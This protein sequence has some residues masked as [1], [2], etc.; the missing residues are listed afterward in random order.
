MVENSDSGVRYFKLQAA[1]N[2]LTQAG[3][4]RHAPV[5]PKPHQVAAAAA[6]S[7]PPTSDT[8]TP[9]VSSTA[10]QAQLRAA[11]PKDQELSR[12]ALA[13]ATQHPEKWH[14]VLQG[15]HDAPEK[16]PLLVAQLQQRVTS[17]PNQRARNILSDPVGARPE[18]CGR[19]S[20]VDVEE[21]EGAED[22]DTNDALMA[23]LTKL[24]QL[25]RSSDQDT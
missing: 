16:L 14:D 13:F 8:P 2:I 20:A 10:L 17:A 6:S 22:A 25:R 18:K 9:A 12:A 24:P 23:Y 4:G 5:A 11:Q 19:P 15:V 21:D 3:G 1:A 7:P